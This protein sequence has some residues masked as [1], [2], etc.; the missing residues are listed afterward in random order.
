[1]Y[2]QNED[3]LMV[4]KIIESIEELRS[5]EDNCKILKGV[6]DKFGIEQPKFEERKKK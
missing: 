6:E 3:Y 5:N 4:L 2:C 1:M